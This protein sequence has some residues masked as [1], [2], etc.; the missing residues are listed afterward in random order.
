[1][2]C[3]LKKLISASS[4]LVTGTKNSGKTSFIN[5]LRQSLALPLHKQTVA[6][7]E[8]KTHAA[9]RASFTSHYLET[10]IESERVGLT[11]WD[12][13]GLEKN[14]V[15][16]QL[17][18]MTA[19]IEARFEETFNEEQ[20]VMRSPGF[21][22]THIH[23]VFLV[24]DPVR[25]D[26]TVAAAAASSAHKAGIAGGLGGLDDDMDL[27]V[28]RAL[29]GKTVVIPVISKADTLTVGHMSF[30]KKA[31]WESLKTAK[32]NPLEEL[33]EDEEEDD[34]EEDDEFDDASEDVAEHSGDD[35]DNVID[36]LVDRSSDE[37]TPAPKPK[38]A[39]NHARQ[40]SLN[41]NGSISG[42]PDEEPFI[43]MSILSP[44][45]YD[46]PPYVSK[47]P[48]ESQVGRRFPWGLASPYDPT[49]CDFTRLRDAIFAEWRS[50]LRELSR[51]RW[52]EQWRTS[53]LKN[54]P[55]SKQRIKGGVTPV[56]AVP[57]E[58]RMSPKT[59]R[60][61]SSGAQTVP[62]SASGNTAGGAQTPIGMAI[63]S[64]TSGSSGDRSISKAERM[65]GIGATESRGGTYRGVESYQ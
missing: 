6:E 38:R 40:A 53:R 9:S 13:A 33:L 10:E 60:N 42:S 32:L 51:V 26:S 36:N 58:G 61:F 14:I 2:S 59:N 64:P 57:R 29:S 18:E 45:P 28:M 17:R 62:R 25:L 46:L 54:V 43:P 12:S 31:V 23:C 30:L 22:D 15:D 47:V 5:F 4:V 21:K 35:D 37:G 20:K 39:S 52:Y 65:M 3:E 24:L 34:E 49:H 48:K 27:Q 41:A 63:G 11:L 1:M 8:S 55:G 50:D 56:A 19:F 44:D 16:L 7:E